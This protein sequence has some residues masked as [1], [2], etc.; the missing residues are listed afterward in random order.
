MDD[1]ATPRTEFAY[2]LRL[3]RE[4]SGTW[5]ASLDDM[6]TRERIYALAPDEIADI[7]ALR[8]DVERTD[9]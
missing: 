4:R 8:C 7:I 2:Y 1:S 3:W 6:A 9:D 5:R